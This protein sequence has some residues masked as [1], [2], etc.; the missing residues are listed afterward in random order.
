MIRAGLKKLHTKQL[1]IVGQQHT[2]D[3]SLAFFKKSLTKSLIFVIF[4]PTCI[5]ELF[6]SVCSM[7]K[8]YTDSGPTCFLPMIPVNMRS[9]VPFFNILDKLRT[10]SKLLK[11]WAPWWRP[12]MP[13]WWIGKPVKIADRLGEQLLTLVKAL[14]KMIL[15]RESWSML[16]VFI[17]GFP[18]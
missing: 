6:S 15:F 17:T 11:W 14:V 5:I 12:Y 7:S 3:F 10:S 2:L 16:G 8:L 1:P 18:R 4:R 9:E 13:F